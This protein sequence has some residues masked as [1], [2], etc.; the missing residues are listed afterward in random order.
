MHTGF[1]TFLDTMK[2]GVRIAAA[3]VAKDQPTTSEGVS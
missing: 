2:G 3:V 1:K